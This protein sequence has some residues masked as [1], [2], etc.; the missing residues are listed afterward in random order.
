MNDMP[1]EAIIWSPKPRET[2]PMAVLPIT[3]VT[4]PLRGIYRTPAIGIVS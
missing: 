3:L 2:P 4:S 1:A